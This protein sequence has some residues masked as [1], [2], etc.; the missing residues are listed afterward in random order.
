MILK[1]KNKDTLVFDQFEIKC[2][3]GKK[4]LN[5]NKIEGDK[6]TPKGVFSFGKIYWRKDRVKKPPTKLKNKIITKNMFW[7]DNPKSKFYNK[8]VIATKGVKSEKL[9][10][11]DI[12]YNYFIVINYNTKKIK[13]NKGSA[14][15]LHLTNDYKKTDGCVAVSQ[16]DFLIICKLISR[17][18]KI[19]IS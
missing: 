13:K 15:F 19:V 1:L 5:N 7:C 4:G 6:T 9:F 16:K 10:R 12:K 18:S 3:I 14:I 11:K 17:D 8:Q 2:A